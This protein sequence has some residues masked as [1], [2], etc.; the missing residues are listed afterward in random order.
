MV[1][2][3]TIHSASEESRRRRAAA[4][5]AAV[6]LLSLTGCVPAWQVQ[7]VGEPAPCEVWVCVDPGGGMERCGC[8]T[9]ARVRAVLEQA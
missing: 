8:H 4:W 5:I 7:R 9:H 1:S 3:M 2:E 6:T